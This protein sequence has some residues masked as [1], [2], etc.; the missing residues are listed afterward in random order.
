MNRIPTIV[1]ATALAVSLFGST[2]LGHAAGRL[3]LPK[4]SV[5]TQQ[6]KA[7]AVTARR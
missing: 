4:N 2:P 6:I 3:I 7:A 1:A 5:G